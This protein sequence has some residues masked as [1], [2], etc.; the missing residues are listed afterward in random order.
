MIIDTAQFI[1]SIS[2]IKH[3]KGH[4]L[5]NSPSKTSMSGE[6]HDLVASTLPPKHLKFIDK[7]RHSVLERP[8]WL[9]LSEQYI[10]SA[11][12]PQ[13]WW[14]IEVG[15]GQGLLHSGEVADSAL[16]WLAEYEWA[17]KENLSR[18]GIDGFWRFRDDGL[19]L[20]KIHF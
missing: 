19:V 9:L 18:H 14:K 16:Y 20:A 3:I 17:S 7:E 10:S 15:T 11:E 8:L 1:K 4:F 5:I 12:L 6:H 2:T 13:R